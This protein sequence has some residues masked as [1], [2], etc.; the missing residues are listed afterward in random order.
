MPLFTKF[1][2]NMLSR[3]QKDTDPD[4]QILI[5]SK[6]YTDTHLGWNSGR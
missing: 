6:L 2:P 5:E 4:I 1:V 3:K